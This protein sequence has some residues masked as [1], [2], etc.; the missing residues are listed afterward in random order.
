M[1]TPATKPTAR[2]TAAK[3]AVATKTTARKAVAKKAVATKAV[4]KKNVPVA[5]DGVVDRV[6]DRISGT[7]GEMTDTASDAY[8]EVVEMA[9]RVVHVYIGLPF[10]AQDR[11]ADLSFDLDDIKAALPRLDVKRLA[12]F[13][14][15]NVDL[16]SVDLTQL[17]SVIAEAE[18]VGHDR[19]TQ[20][21]H[22]IESLTAPVSKR[23][24]GRFEQVSEKI[25]SQLPEQVRDFV[26]SS[27]KRMRSLVAA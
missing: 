2:K 23:V 5:A 12:S 7:V 6:A 20:F 22:R 13:D 1:A 15:T 8:T 21:Q 9:R 24:D 18:Q 4:A 16:P 17:K 25:E 14:F 3:K 26:A 19:V 27:R 10:V 11:L